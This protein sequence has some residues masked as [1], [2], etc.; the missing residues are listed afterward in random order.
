MA[1]NGKINAGVEKTT[2][3]R[4]AATARIVCKK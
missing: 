2:T 4:E 3:P 1:I